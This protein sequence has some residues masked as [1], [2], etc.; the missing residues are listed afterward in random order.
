M[1]GKLHSCLIPTAGV[2][3]TIAALTLLPGCNNGRPSVSGEVTFNGQ[4]VAEGTISLEPAD[5]NGPSVGGKIVRG[6]YEL[7]GNA[8]PLPGKKLVRIS[9][10]HKTGRKVQARMSQPTELVDEV[11][12]LIPPAYNTRSKL[13]CEVTAT[14]PNRCDFHLKSP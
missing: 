1:I 9:A 13:S 7:T 11:A 5:G 4:P 12:P 10:T 3:A 2:L 14:G 8:A 6:K